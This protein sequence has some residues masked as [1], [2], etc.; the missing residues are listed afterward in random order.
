MSRL[1]GFDLKFIAGIYVSK[2]AKQQGY[3]TNR[4]I[5]HCNVITVKQ[6]DVFKIIILHFKFLMFPHIE[7]AWKT[8]STCV[9][10]G[11]SKVVIGEKLVRDYVLI[12]ALPWFSGVSHK[13]Q[14]YIISYERLWAMPWALSFGYDENKWYNHTASAQQCTQY[15]WTS[16]V[17]IEHVG[18]QAVSVHQL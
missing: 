3:D 13:E 4:E 11:M 9:G 17:S 8:P 1:I 10:C 7:C 14:G 6:T 5:I 2:I 15:M 12:S 18:P 16:R